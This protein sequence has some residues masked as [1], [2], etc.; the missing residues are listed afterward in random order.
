M[1]NGW[2]EARSI[3][4]GQLCVTEAGALYYV[5]AQYP[6]GV[7]AYTIMK[8]SET[9]QLP[10]DLLVRPIDLR[11]LLERAR[12]L[13]AENA[14]M[15]R[16]V[17]DRREEAS[18]W[19]EHGAAM[20]RGAAVDVIRRLSANHWP[21]INVRPHLNQALAVLE[22]AAEAIAAR[23]PVLPQL[24]SDLLRAENDRLRAENE[25]LRGL[26]EQLVNI[27]AETVL[28][29]PTS[30]CAPDS[31]GAVLRRAVEIASRE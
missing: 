15:A 9:H 16:I 14:E 21:A 25:R 18:P 29:T 11:S 23:G 22:A 3:S 24:P 8:G 20:E 17:H 10:L 4:P 31:V 6:F 30:G 19:I 5:R 12:E 1:S 27:T 26:N 28:N 2:V 7:R 13:E